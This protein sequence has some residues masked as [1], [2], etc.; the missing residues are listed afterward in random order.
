MAQGEG[1]YFRS[2][3]ASPAPPTQ[4]PGTLK[5]GR[6]RKAGSGLLGLLAIVLFLLAVVRRRALGALCNLSGCLCRSHMHARSR[7]SCPPFLVWLMPHCLQT[8]DC[9]W[10][11][12][13]L[14]GA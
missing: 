11:L 7:C 4:A 2:R 12:E 1:I 9:I 6:K 5:S 8:A 3:A 13:G 14:G 10:P